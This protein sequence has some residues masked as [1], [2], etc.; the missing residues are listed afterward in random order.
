MTAKLVPLRRV[1]GDITE[2]SDE[3]LLA[4][5]GTGDAP[6][7]G[8]LF[9]RF[10]LA[11]YRFA[12]RLPMTDDL[13]RDD[14]VQATFLEVQR[15]APSFRGTSSVKTWILGIAANI[16]RHTLRS[17]RRRRVHQAR[18]L[19]RVDAAAESP[20]AQLERRK[21]LAR[22]AEALSRLPRDQQIAFILCDLEQLP[23][24]EVARVLD[25]PE[26]TLWRRLHTARKAMRQAIEKVIDK[27]NPHEAPR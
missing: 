10:H 23:G 20:D 19:E 21:L 17:E 4:A 11:V 25:I 2:M 13:A 16:A 7:L 15:A 24:V 26:G 8:A 9:D 22:I 6:A 5:C 3:A 12:S 18:F 14:L 27:A 1:S